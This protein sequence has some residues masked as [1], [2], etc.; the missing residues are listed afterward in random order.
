MAC[1]G[2]A[3]AGTV[4]EEGTV[5]I[6]AVAGNPAV[7]VG[8]VAAGTPAADTPAAG[9]PPPASADI[10]LSDIPPPPV[11]ADIR[12]SDTPPAAADILHIQAR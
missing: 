10:R 3:A 9:I 12:L 5:G 6:A 7:E 2:A 8:R 11:L 4:A 1:D